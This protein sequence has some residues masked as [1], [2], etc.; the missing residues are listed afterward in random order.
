MKL[1]LVDLDLFSGEALSV[2]AVQA[3]DTQ[4]TSHELLVEDLRKVPGFPWL[5]Q[6]T[7]LLPSD[8]TAPNELTVSV[9]ARGQASNSAKVRIQ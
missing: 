4:Q 8:L 5:V 1:F 3:R 7:V 9:S 6:L 2:I